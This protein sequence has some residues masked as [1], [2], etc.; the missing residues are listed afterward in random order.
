M[1]FRYDK[2]LHI[3]GIRL[4]HIGTMFG[5]N[6]IQITILGSDNKFEKKVILLHG[7]HIIQV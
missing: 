5:D 1:S 2:I 3:Y 4:A 6:R 7:I